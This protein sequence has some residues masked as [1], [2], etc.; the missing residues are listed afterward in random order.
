[1]EY[2]DFYPTRVWMDQC[3]LDNS[4]LENKIKQF[5]DNHQSDQRSNVGGYQGE[6]FIDEEL[7]NNIIKRIP[8]GEQMPSA[9][10][11]SIKS[12]VNVNN[13]GDYNIR[14]H[15]LSTKFLFSGVYYVKVPENS[16]RFRIYDPRG[17]WVKGFQDWKY[18][19]NNYEC[20]HIEPKEGLLMLFPCWMEHDVEPSDSDEERISISFNLWSMDLD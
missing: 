9:L 13:R 7:N 16:G 8:I 1:M 2:M 18:Y 12:W 20:Y 5:T 19:N 4:R 10:R 17:A 11:W 3:D 14:H 6:D 15:H